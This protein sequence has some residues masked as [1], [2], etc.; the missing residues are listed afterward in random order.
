MSFDGSHI[1]QGT[2]PF[3]GSLFGEN[4]SNKKVPLGEVLPWACSVSHALE[5]LIQALDEEDELLAAKEQ[6]FC[7]IIN[8]CAMVHARV[9]QDSAL[10]PLT[11]S[12]D[13]VTPVPVK[14]VP[15]VCSQDCS[16]SG[17]GHLVPLCK[18]W[19]FQVLPYK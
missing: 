18:R 17:Q 15:G 1:S 9:L 4:L 16:G 6:L 19:C 11:P 14:S 13:F 3:L 2:L 12:L 10:V 8:T 7:C 5:N